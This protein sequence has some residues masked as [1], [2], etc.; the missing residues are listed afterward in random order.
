MTTTMKGVYYEKH[1]NPKDVLKVGDLPIPQIQHAEDVLI[2]VHAASINP[3][4]FK[5][6]ESKADFILMDRPLP[7]KPGFD[8][9]GVIVER[10]TSVDGRLQVGMEVCGMI[11]G[12]RTG[13]TCEY[14]VV[15][16]EVISIKPQRLAHEQ[17]A[18]IPLAAITAFQCLERGLDASD[19]SKNATKSV[20]CTGG[21]GGVGTF[22]IQLAKHFFK[23]GRV[24]TT[25]SGGEKTALCKRLGAD[26]VVNYREKKF[27]ELREQFDCLVD[28]TAEASHMVKIAKDNGVIMSITQSPTQACLVEWINHM[29]PTPGITLRAPIKA[30]IT[31]LPASVIELFTGAL[32]LNHNSRGVKFD[33]LITKPN[34]KDLDTILAFIDKTPSFEIVID[35][36]F[37]LEQGKEAYLRSESGK[38]VGKVVVRAVRSSSS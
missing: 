12:L 24:V 1:G 21:P 20:F 26:D 17:A 4:D 38:A 2:K 32:K 13:T 11:R 15:N 28:C 35:T 5:Q 16:Q 7:I 10:G 6:C 14:V 29:G 30:I 33:H 31:T 19:T 18:A 34:H 9:S 37:E 3:A 8:F 22:I 25:A 23:A 36:I 27:W